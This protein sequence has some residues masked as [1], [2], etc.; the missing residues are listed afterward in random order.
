MIE[1]TIKNLIAEI[2]FVQHYI[3]TSQESGFNDMT[4]LL[5]SMSIKLFKATHDLTLVNNNFLKANFPAIDL[6]DDINKIAIQVTSNA[7]AKKI[8]HTIQMFE[9]FKFDKKYNKLLIFGFLKSSKNLKKL[10]SYCSIISVGDLVSILTDKHDEELIQNVR[11][12][13]L[14]H[15]DFS[16]THP[17]EDLNCL[18]ITL[19]CINRNAIKHKI[20]CEGSYENMSKGL[21]E[22]TELISKG[23]INKKN[24]SKSINEFQDEIIKVFLQEVRNKIG[25]I[26]AIV[27]KNRQPDSNT[28]YIKDTDYNEIDN[29][30][31]A[32][33]KLSNEISKQFK[34]NILLEQI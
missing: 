12:C 13:I 20:Y 2:T 31:L 3:K 16:K 14:Q 10:P 7:D 28:V 26:T 11:D 33:I 15:T 19:N 22:I 23:T 21:N 8:R 5:E 4:R 30:K 34:C 17:Y 9:K 18:K 25:L 6:S 24:I 32:I 1:Q 29:I 27:N